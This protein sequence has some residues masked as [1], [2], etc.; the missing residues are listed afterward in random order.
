MP[1]GTVKVNLIGASAIKDSEWIGK[2]DPYVVIMCGKREVTSNVAKNQGSTPVWNQKFHFYVDD[3]DT[4]VQIKIYNEN[5]LQTDDI[6]GTTTISLSDAFSQK[7]LPVTQYT[8]EPRGDI[9]LQISYTPKVKPAV[10]LTQSFPGPYGSQTH[11]SPYV[12]AQ[13]EAKQDGEYFTGHYGQH[14]GQHHG[15]STRY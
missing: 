6:I 9:G 1:A 2:G 15:S 8:L 13:P 11:S 4:D 5:A 7:K 12:Q 10:R 3:S 14:H